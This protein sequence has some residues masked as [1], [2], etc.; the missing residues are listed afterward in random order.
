MWIRYRNWSLRKKIAL[1][2]FM[3]A[4]TVIAVSIW[5]MTER[6]QKLAIDQAIDI[7]DAKAM[8]SSQDI[9]NT[10]NS[11]MSVSRT[12]QAVFD[13]AMKADPIPQRAYFAKVLRAVLDSHPE[14]SGTWVACLP[15]TFDGRE[16]EY[17][18]VWNGTM[19][20]Y[21]YRNG[22][23]VE[24]AYE[25][26]ETLNG[27]WFD[28]PMA[29]TGETI[30]KPY[31]WEVNGT[32]NWVA[33]TGF[34]VRKGNKNI[35]VV[36]VDFYLTELQEMVEKIKPYDTGY[37]FLTGNDG[38][39]IAHP[40][41]DYL[42]KSLTELL[43][44]AHR[45]SC[46]D[47]VASGKRYSF[48]AP[49]VATGRMEYVTAMPVSIGHSTTPWSLAVAIPLAEVKDKA[50]T[51]AN[52]GMIIGGAAVLILLVLVLCLAQVIVRPILR[53]V[54]Y[55]RTIADGNLDISLDIEQKDEIG[56]MADSLRKMVATLRDFIAQAES[57]T[58]QAE[59]ESEKARQ[60]MA[61]AEEARNQ[62]VEARKAGLQH[63][64]GRVS[65]VLDGIVAAT[66][67][68]TRQADLLL[69]DAQ[70]QRDRVSSTATAMEEMN[71]TVLEIARNAGDASS[72]GVQAR[73]P[74][75]KAPRPWTLPKTP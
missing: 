41:E 60:A 28:L 58:R 27:D 47:A 7:A 12:L 17:K 36:G 21:H 13:E 74:Q 71:A 6:T 1:P 5:F 29:G 33:S 63:A 75:R 19:R 16:D 61:D 43:D 53:T 9:M 68:M 24:T 23:S 54:E 14:L 57:K 20:V 31:P 55:A 39:I 25:G 44:G 35:G 2:I 69:N 8:S 42:G 45:Q 46:L 11:A 59:E 15:N 32:T 26:A 67:Q 37:A 72:A 40:Q 18:A 3:A 30:T 48:T 62:A 64:A 34:P 10:L 4:I 38:T 52:T 73:R 50:R 66:S 70:E 51:V 56:V 49:N 65:T 22:G